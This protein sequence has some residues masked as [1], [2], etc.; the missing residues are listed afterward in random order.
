[1]KVLLIITDYGSFNNFLSEVAVQLLNAGH[2]VHVVCSLVKIINCKDKYPYREMGIIF[3]YFDFPRSFNFFSQIAA[4]KK[5][6]KRIKEINP[7]LINIHFTTGIFTTVIWRKPPYFTIGTIH[8]LGYPVIKNRLKRIVFELVEKFCFKNLDQIYLINPFDYNLVK[9]LYPKKAFYYNSFGV[10]CDL[11]KFDPFSIPNDFRKKLRRKLL[12]NDDDFVL[13]FTG[14]FVAF[15]GF[16]IVIKAVNYLNNKFKYRNIK[17]LII[18]GVDPIHETGLNKIEETEYKNN[19]NIIQ[20]DFTAD[21]NLYLS[22]SNAFVFPSEK[23]GMP[24][25]IMEALAMGVPVITSNSRGCNDLVENSFNGLLLS[26]NPTVEETREAILKLYNDRSLLKRLS[27][28]AL[29]KRNE[30]NRERYV[31]NQIEIY[32]DISLGDYQYA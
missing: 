4:S 27:S 2:E 32:N 25:C 1:M 9:K 20:I 28:N 16:D 6:N 31:E 17:L 30:F 21:V 22:I 19:E 29:S 24:V 11:R 23:E 8:G 15:K 26:D 5:I 13:A 12:I 10:G 3:H 14:R 18:G 7:D